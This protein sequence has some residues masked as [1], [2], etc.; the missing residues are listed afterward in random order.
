MAI[1]TSK[2]LMNYDITNLANKLKIKNFKGVFMRDTL[3]DKI[4]DKEYGI[5]NLDLSK[6]NRTYWVY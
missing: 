4:N 5:A 3:P 1:K 6:N 2:P